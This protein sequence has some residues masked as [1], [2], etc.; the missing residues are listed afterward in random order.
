LPRWCKVACPTARRREFGAG[1]R[2]GAVGPPI[3][4]NI[5][6]RVARGDAVCLGRVTLNNPAN[7]TRGRC[8]IQ[9]FRT[10][11]MQRRVKFSIADRV[12][13]LATSCAC[14]TMRQKSIGV[15]AVDLIPARTGHGPALGLDALAS[16]ANMKKNSAVPVGAGYTR[17]AHALAGYAQTV[18]PDEAENVASGPK[19]IRCRLEITHRPSAKLPQ[20]CLRRWT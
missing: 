13:R 18:E 15:R 16:C 7:G 6:C 19:T 12:L 8:N 20:G 11:P 17:D 10:A 2:A 1:S 4:A 14:R 5:A 3:R 9:P